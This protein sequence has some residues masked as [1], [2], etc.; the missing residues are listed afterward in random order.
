M[1]KK[2]VAIY[3]ISVGFG[4]SG[5]F[6]NDAIEK[7]SLGVKN[8]DANSLG[9]LGYAW[10]PEEFPTTMKATTTKKESLVFA[11]VFCTS[12]MY[13]RNGVMWTSKK[14]LKLDIF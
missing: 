9:G 14:T 7:E 12:W 1:F 2:A 13:W 3:L 8:P 10:F 11:G 4:L 6:L 5:M